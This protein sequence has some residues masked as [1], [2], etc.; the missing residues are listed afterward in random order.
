M[1]GND[2]LPKP[3]PVRTRY[4]GGVGTFILPTV[5]MQW[6][7][8]QQTYAATLAACDTLVWIV[9]IDA[10]NHARKEG[11]CRCVVLMLTPA[12]HSPTDTHPPPSLILGLRRRVF[13]V[14]V[15]SAFA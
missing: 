14:A 9:N 11:L 7:L 2:R 5:H 1:A 15:C 13:A 3:H 10:A 6:R 4:R 12:L 8:V